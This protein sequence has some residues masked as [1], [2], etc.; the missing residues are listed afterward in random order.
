[1]PT[2]RELNRLEREQAWIGDAVLNL[3][4]REWV[5]EHRGRVEA[6]LFGDLTS[7]RFLSTLG[8]PTAVEAHLGRVYLEGGLPAAAAWL[9]DTLIA[10][11]EKQ[12]QRKRP[13]PGGRRARSS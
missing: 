11:F 7:N 1:L 6:E 3:L 5:L 12:R 8:S 9:E 4:A 13:G 10:S 2:K